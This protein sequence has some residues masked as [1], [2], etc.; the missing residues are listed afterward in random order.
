MQDIARPRL[1]LLTAEQRDAVH[2]ASL[3][4]LARSGLRLDSERA[5]DVCRRG[6]ARGLRPV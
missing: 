3:S 6:D 2:E 1:T 4:I 5:R